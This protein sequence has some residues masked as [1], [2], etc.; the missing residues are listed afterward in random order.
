MKKALLLTILILVPLHLFAG[1]ENE[2]K[3]GLSFLKIGINARAAG[4]SEAYTAVAA[5]ASATYWNPAGLVSASFS[6]VLFHHN[7]WIEGIR[8]EFAALSFVREKSAWGIHVRSF[9]IGDIPVRVIPSENPL[10]KTSAHYL[11]AGLS[12]A[13]RLSASLDV[14]ATV[15]YLFE[16]IYVESSTGFALDVGMMY[17][18]PF[19]NLRFGFVLQNLGKM[20]ALYAEKT[21]LPQIS[22]L[23]VLYDFPLT[24]RNIAARAAVDLVKPSQENVRLHLGGE[25]VL[26]KQIA[27]RAGFMEGY[28]AKSYSFGIGVLRSTVR[29]DYALTPF[30]DDLGSTHRFSLNFAL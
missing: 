12:Y 29:F 10:E 25:F 30:T 13:R 21:S 14:G 15:K 11:S 1:F 17:R 3:T 23:G 5:D 8:G 28:E 20:N 19:P 18:S 22:R 27:L 2:G 9:N 4:M 26:W 7:E 24:S 16:K 6:N